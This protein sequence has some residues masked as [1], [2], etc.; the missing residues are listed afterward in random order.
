MGVS[1][2]SCRRFVEGS[3][4]LFVVQRKSLDRRCRRF[5]KTG[6]R[7]FP[8]QAKMLDGGCRRFISLCSDRSFPWVAG[9]SW[10]WLHCPRSLI[11]AII[12]LYFI[13][14]SPLCAGGIPL[15]FSALIQLLVI[16]QFCKI[17]LFFANQLL[18]WRWNV[19]FLDF[20]WVPS[21][22]E[23]PEKRSFEQGRGSSTVY[24]LLTLVVLTLTIWLREVRLLIRIGWVW[25]LV[26]V[27][28]NALDAG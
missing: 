28:F 8:R 15:P 13:G 10:N 12:H 27:Y 21:S 2:L 25:K 23:R 11:C 6:D 4:R 14:V 3:D 22:C 26:I 7:L 9:N 1:G 16:Y 17:A 24:F 19:N 5:R 18:P 20:G